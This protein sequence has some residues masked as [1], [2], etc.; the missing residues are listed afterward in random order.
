MGSTCTQ[1]KQPT[2]QL[3]L[4][5]PSANTAVRANTVPESRGHGTAHLNTDCVMGLPGLLKRRQSMRLRP[6]GGRVALPHL[7]RPVATPHPGPLL[8]SATEEFT[9]PSGSFP[10]VC[11][12]RRL[13]AQAYTGGRVDLGAPQRPGHPRVPPPL[14]PMVS[15]AMAHAQHQVKGT[16]KLKLRRRWR[17]GGIESDPSSFLNC[18]TS[19]K[20]PSL[21]PDSTP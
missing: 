14:T 10:E 2:R 13:P 11:Q 15:M 17:R 12:P 16:M 4:P 21:G 5:A 3:T 18:V 6:T 9:D 1:L 20:F 7:P 19:T 8:L